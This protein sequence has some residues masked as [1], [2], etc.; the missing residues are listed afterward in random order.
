MCTLPAVASLT[1]VIGE[2]VRALRD[3][4]AIRLEDVAVAARRHGL[5]W[6]TG[7]V[8]DLEVG[9]RTLTAVELVLLP[10]LL[11]AACGRRISLTDL[12]PGAGRIQLTDFA[13]SPASYVRDVLGG[14]VSRNGLQLAAP[15]PVKAAVQDARS[16]FALL[17]KLGGESVQSS[18]LSSWVRAAH[19]VEEKTAIRLG[20]PLGVIVVAGRQLWGRSMAAERDERVKPPSTNARRNQAKRGHATRQLVDEMRSYLEERGVL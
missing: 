12:L 13:S 20:L 19:P 7:S 9:R 2:Q 8:A 18:D 17:K 16:T 1:Q 15:E 6:S 14:R 3:A 10:D 5:R 11:S 4:H